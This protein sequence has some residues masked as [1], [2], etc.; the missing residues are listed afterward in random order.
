MS[1]PI[2]LIT[3]RTAEPTHTASVLEL[4]PAAAPPPALLEEI[5]QAAETYDE[6][7]ASGHELAFTPGAAGE[8]VAVE[9]RDTGGNVLETLSIADALELAAGKPLR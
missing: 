6:L 9:V 7:Y 1:S 3:G 5:A 4:G 2:K 8:R